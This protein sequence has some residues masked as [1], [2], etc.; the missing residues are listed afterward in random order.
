LGEVF[1]FFWD[2]VSERK[3]RVSAEILKEGKEVVEGVWRMR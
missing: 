2:G 1:E 3:R